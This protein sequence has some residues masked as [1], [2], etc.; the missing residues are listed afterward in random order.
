MI[1]PT[2]SR[3][4]CPTL[5]REHAIRVGYLDLSSLDDPDHFERTEFDCDVIATDA[6]ACPNRHDCPLFT[7]CPTVRTF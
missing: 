7:K 6:E 3:G 1:V 4:F 5:G 2:I